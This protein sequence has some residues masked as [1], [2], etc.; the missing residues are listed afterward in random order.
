MEKRLLVL[1]L[2]ILFASLNS[3]VAQTGEVT[4]TG[5]IVD[6]V[7]YMASGVKP[8]SPQNLEIIQ[9]SARGGNPL[10]ILEDGSGRLYVVTMKQANTGSNQTLLPWL[11]SRITAKGKVYSKGSTSVLVVTTIGKGAK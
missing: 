3:M 7:S 8:D 4:I 10:G 1:L 11:G 6:L 5:E 2:I 9:G